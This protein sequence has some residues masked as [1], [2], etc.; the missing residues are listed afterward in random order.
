MLQL[1]L[2]GTFQ[3]LVAVFIAG[4]PAIII[5]AVVY[6]LLTGES[7]LAGLTA[8]YGGLYHIPGIITQRAYH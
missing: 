6:Q 1:A 5:G 3:K 2:G 4:I 7:W 8:I